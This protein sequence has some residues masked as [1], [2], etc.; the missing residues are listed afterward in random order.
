MDNKNQGDSLF[1]A[2]FLKTKKKL[3]FDVL[4][5]KIEQ[6]KKNLIVLTEDFITFE[7]IKKIINFDNPSV[8]FVES[9]KAVEEYC[10]NNSKESSIILIDVN[11][12]IKHNLTVKALTEHNKCHT[13]IIFSE[14]CIDLDFYEGSIVSDS[15][16]GVVENYEQNKLSLNVM[17]DNAI[18]KHFQTGMFKSNTD[19][20]DIYV[21]NFKKE[22]QHT[23]EEL[24]LLMKNF[25]DHFS[26]NEKQIEFLIVEHNTYKDKVSVLG[27]TKNFYS[28][29]M[30]DNDNDLVVDVIEK[31]IEEKAELVYKDY[32]SFYFSNDDF[33][34]IIFLFKNID[35]AI[36]LSRRILDLVVTLNSG[37]ILSLITSSMKEYTLISELERFYFDDK[38]KMK[39]HKLKCMERFVE[40]LS[41]N[42]YDKKNLYHLFFARELDIQDVIDIS[43]LINLLNKAIKGRK[44]SKA[45]K[46]VLKRSN[47]L[48]FYYSIIH[49]VDIINHHHH[50][51]LFLDNDFGLD[52]RVINAVTENIILFDFTS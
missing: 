32:Q 34:E 46:N 2:T 25:F 38:E 18:A 15:T 24:V 3:M 12:L 40:F 8:L 30:K 16:F 11:I 6:S 36:T 49:A 52:K 43:E 13:V 27:K 23:I 14:N 48:F 5:E 50:A 20:I 21:D 33:T 31:T 47:K 37:Y 9:Q 10:K 42:D 39:N 28:K 41:I 29:R 44:G 22:K 1:M 19:A 51:N 7:N 45:A 35:S 17:I 4:K 26:D